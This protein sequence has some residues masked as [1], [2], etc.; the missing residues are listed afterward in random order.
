M[1]TTSAIGRV[2]A[3]FAAA[4]LFVATT[5]HARTP[6]EPRFLDLPWGSTRTAV[7][8]RLV[9]KGYTTIEQDQEGDLSFKSIDQSPAVTGWAFFSAQGAL[10][11]IV[12]KHVT[13]DAECLA[14]YRFMVD[15]LGGK[16]GAPDTQVERYDSPFE[17]GDGYEQTAI[18]TGKG[19]LA[20]IWL[21]QEATEDNQSGVMID[22]TTSLVVRI[23]YEPP[24]WS[25]ESD[26]RRASQAQDF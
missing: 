20:T 6:V 24:V 18:K 3:P 19:H 1:P 14:H 12:V 7:E 21:T 2:A 25:A 11:K 15:L 26:R 8:A 22:V 16:Y 4:L 9:A 13:S 10:V 23:T 17:V 5:V